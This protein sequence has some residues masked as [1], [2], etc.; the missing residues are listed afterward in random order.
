MV[1]ETKLDLLLKKMEENERKRAEAEE[2]TRADLAELKK[3]VEARLPLV[4]KRVEEVASVV[5]SLST[6]VEN[7]DGTLL[8]QGRMEKKPA[9]VKEEQF[10]PQSSFQIQ[11]MRDPTLNSANN[12][13]FEPIASPGSGSARTNLGSSLPPMTCPQFNGDNPQMWRANCEVY[14]DVYGIPPSNWVK[15]ATLNFVGNAAF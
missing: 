10:T 1:H 13:N 5:G 7:M 8:K 14:F 3:V 15:I 12:F 2:R 9:D 6:K 4:E 11:G